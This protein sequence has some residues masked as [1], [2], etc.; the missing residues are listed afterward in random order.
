MIIVQRKR[1]GLVIPAD[2]EILFFGAASL[3]PTGWS[4]DTAA[5]AAFVRGCDAGQGSDTP[6]GASSHSHTNPSATGT[7]GSHTH[8]LSGSTTTSANVTG[9]DTEYRHD[10]FAKSH[11]HTVGGTSVSG[12]SHS[13]TLSSTGSS[14][15]LPPYLRLYWIK[16]TK[17]NQIPIKGVLVW[18]GAVEN[19]PAGYYL[20][21]GSNSTPDLRSKFVYGAS[22]D[23]HIGTTGGATS[24]THTNSSTGTSSTHTH[25]LTPT[26][27]GS[28]LYFTGSVN[29][30]ASA[31]HGH[32]HSVS[33][34]SNSGGGHSHTLGSTGSASNLPAYIKLYYIM[35]GA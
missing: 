7:G 16:A 15:A 9:A 18:N 25:T 5:G 27:G 3:I 10:N 23:S 11:T 22:A 20:C 28:S 8:G 30:T 34:T 4:I 13:H 26:I 29:T 14:S 12:G 32:S 1:S 17:N 19:I 21:N 6:A 35:R 31:R 2:G 24:H 33:T